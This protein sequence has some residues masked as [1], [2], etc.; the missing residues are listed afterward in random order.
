M[1]AFFNLPATQAALGVDKATTWATCNYNVNGQFASD[2]MKQFAEPYISSQ[3]EA[4]T[5]VLIYAG[6]VDF[7]CNWLGNQAWTM[8]LEWSGKAGFNAAVPHEWTDATGAVAG[9]ARTY[10]GLTFLQVYNGGH[11]VP[12]DQPA[13]ALSLLNQLTSGA[14]F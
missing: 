4:G 14:P 9:K 10:G 13:A 5:R 6:D 1:T 8:Q 11:M 2:W 3:L 12:A 7:I